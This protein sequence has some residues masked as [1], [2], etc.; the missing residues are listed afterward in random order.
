MRDNPSPVKTWILPDGKSFSDIFGHHEN[1]KGFPK[2]KH[3]RT[4]KKTNMCLKYAS[5]G[6]CPRGLLCNLAHYNAKSLN[7][8]T[9]TQAGTRFKAVYG[10]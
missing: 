1:R 3:H 8:D 2:I 6:N 7:T 4:G 5:T 10:S 9:Q